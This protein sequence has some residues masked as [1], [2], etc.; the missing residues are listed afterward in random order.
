MLIEQIIEFGIEE[1]WAPWPYIMYFI[2]LFIF[3]TWQNKN[4]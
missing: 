4:L 3:M 1:A 2:Q